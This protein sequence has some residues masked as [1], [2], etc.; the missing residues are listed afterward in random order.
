MALR[1]GSINRSNC[2]S[3]NNEAILP[4]N[5]LTL[6]IGDGFRKVAADS[7]LVKLT[8]HIETEVADRWFSYRLAPPATLAELHRKLGPI[9]HTTKQEERNFVD[10][11]DNGMVL[12]DFAARFIILAY[13]QKSPY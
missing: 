10:N 13:N 5:G 8:A 7:W 4:D 3:F 2:F 12:V 6:E 11:E 9:A 1:N